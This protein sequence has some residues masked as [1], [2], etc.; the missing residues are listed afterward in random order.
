MGDTIRIQGAEADMS[1]VVA[2][3]AVAYTTSSAAILG[4]AIDTTLYPAKRIFVIFNHAADATSTGVTLTVTE[5]ASSGGSY[6]A[7]TKTGTVAASNSARA[8]VVQV[9]RNKAKPWIKTSITPA[10]G[11]GV[12]SATLLFM[13]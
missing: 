11:S 7:S 1:A 8:T 9:A 12:V 2:T 13:R 6:T 5:S 3:A 4:T 10:G